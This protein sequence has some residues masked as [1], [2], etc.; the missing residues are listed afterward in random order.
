MCDV[1]KFCI[2]ISQDELDVIL[3]HFDEARRLSEAM[4]S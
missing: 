2:T 4:E 3:A 1:P